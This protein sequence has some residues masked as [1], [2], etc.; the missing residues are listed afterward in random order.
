M[1]YKMALPQLAASCSFN[2]IMP[3][4][5][6]RDLLVFAIKDSEVGATAPAKEDEPYTKLNR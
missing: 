4:G 2:M 1:Q 3:E 6:L 5:I